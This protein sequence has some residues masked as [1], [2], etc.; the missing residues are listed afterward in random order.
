MVDAIL[1]VGGLWACAKRPRLNSRATRGWVNLCPCGRGSIVPVDGTS[2][3]PIRAC[4]EPFAVCRPVPLDRPVAPVCTPGQAGGFRG[5]AKS[6]TGNGA[7]E[8]AG[9]GHRGGPGTSVSSRT[10]SWDRLDGVGERGIMGQAV[11]TN[12][13]T[14]S[15]ET[16]GLQPSQS[17]DCSRRG[18][19]CLCGEA[20]P[21]RLYPSLTREL[22]QETT[23]NGPCDW[24]GI[25]GVHGYRA[26]R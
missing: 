12:G 17:S 18:C 8:L 6:P 22:N 4:G 20:G 3:C 24:Q 10:V 9:M 21:K 2:I 25:R 26:N 16:K 5:G 13:R 19:D 23:N 1:R 11:D 14:K 15:G 7:P